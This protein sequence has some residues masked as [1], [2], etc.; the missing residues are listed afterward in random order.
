[1]E[2]NAQENVKPRYSPCDP[3]SVV[4]TFFT[5]DG[6]KKRKRLD[7]G[8]NVGQGGFHSGPDALEIVLYR[9][10]KEAREGSE[11]YNTHIIK[12]INAILADMWTHNGGF[13]PI[14]FVRDT[15]GME[16]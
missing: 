10:S 4:S 6:G 9:C 15:V 13:P 7:N 16:R 1:M 12:C 14:I 3:V 2:F 5:G 11:L 8:D